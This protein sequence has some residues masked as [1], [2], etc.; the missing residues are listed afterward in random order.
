MNLFFKI[1]LLDDAGG[2]WIFNFW[3]SHLIWTAKKCWS[4]HVFYTFFLF[5]LMFFHLIGLIILEL[6]SGNT[7][8]ENFFLVFIFLRFLCNRI[9][10]VWSLKGTSWVIFWSQSLVFFIF[11]VSIVHIEKSYLFDV[12]TIISGWVGRW[13]LYYFLVWILN[14]AI[15]VQLHGFSIFIAFLHF[16]VL[17]RIEKWSIECR[18]EFWTFFLILALLFWTILSMAQHIA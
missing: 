4:R 17:P 6:W 10:L 11:L 8:I 1:K 9:M 3:R 15:I 13:W 16:L 14:H 5:F 18:G 12:W 2:W 7:L